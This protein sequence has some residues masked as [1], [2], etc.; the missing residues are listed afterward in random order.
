MN[1]LRI[2]VAILV[3]CALV[4][5]VGCQTGIRSTRV[6]LVTVD[7]SM[8]AWSEYV[9]SGKASPDQ[10]AKVHAAYD[11][12]WATVLVARQVALAVKMAESDTNQ[13]NQATT[14]KNQL[15]EAIAALNASEPELISL[16]LQLLPVKKAA[17]LKGLL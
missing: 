16:I 8:A 15:Q 9:H 4:G 2:P 17:E 13:V 6:A 3:L 10:V 5:L 11:K 14:A 7:A 12:Y 1:N